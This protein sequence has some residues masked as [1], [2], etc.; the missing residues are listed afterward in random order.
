MLEQN[1]GHDGGFL[2]CFTFM[3]SGIYNKFSYFHYYKHLAY[4][5]RTYQL[6]ATA[7][8]LICVYNLMKMS[9]EDP[10]EQQPFM[11]QSSEGAECRVCFE[12]RD[13]GVLF[14]PCKCD[15]SVKYIHIACLEQWR[16][17][18]SNNGRAA[19]ECPNCHYK[20]KFGRVSSI[21]WMSNPSFIVGVTLPVVFAFLWWCYLLTE[22]TL[23][24]TG[25][26]ALKLFDLENNFPDEEQHTAYMLDRM[27]T[28]LIFFAVFGF[29]LS[30]I[31]GVSLPN[32]CTGCCRNR[33]CR[34]RNCRTTSSGGGG[35]GMAAILVAIFIIVG[36]INGCYGVYDCVKS[37]VVKG[38]DRVQEYVV[39]SRE[40][41]GE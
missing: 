40:G 25:G 30:F 36:F 24:L 3:K 17:S 6:Y 38:R 41:E 28:S 11:R 7:A 1:I 27:I 39:D 10:E 13:F 16:N 32:P 34:S 20:Y 19:T 14:K 18:G 9:S 35:R 12:G 21:E 33:N 29:I 8:T 37:Y 5:P 26:I 15:G 4:Q 2:I 23:P 31:R 22:Y